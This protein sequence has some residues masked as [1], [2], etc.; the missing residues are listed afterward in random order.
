MIATVSELEA[1]TLEMEKNYQAALASLVQR[2][3]RA[4]GA[5]A[6][7]KGADQETS[8]KRKRC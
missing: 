8:R 1:R 4:E 7:A 2:C 6:P 5:L 3:E